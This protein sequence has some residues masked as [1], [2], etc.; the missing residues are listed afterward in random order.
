MRRTIFLVII[1]GFPLFR[2]AAEFQLDFAGAAG[3][4][5]EA[6][7]ELQNEYMAAAIRE[8]AWRWGIRAYMPRLSITASEDDRLSEI[9]ADSFLKNYSVNLDQLIWDGGR[10]P[11]SRRMEKADQDLARS[12]L[13]QMA[14]NIADSAVSAYSYVL[15]GRRILEIREKALE[16]LDE[17]RRIMQREAGLGLIRPLDLAD[18]EITI[19]LE[20]LEIQS[21]SMDLEEAEWRFREML[22][23]AELPLLSERIDT[24]K[25]LALPGKQAV[26]ALA[27]S[28]N[29]ELAAF[30]YSIARRQAE[31]KAVSLSWCPT[32]RMTGSFALSG[33]RYPLSRYSWSVGLSVDFSS[34]WLSGNLSAQTGRD[35]PY[36]KNARLQQTAS[37][38]P[39]PGA[40]FS[41]RSAELALAYERT[42]YETALREIHSAADRSLNECTMLDRKR[43]LAARALELEGEKFRLAELRL[44]LGEIT[45]LDLMEARLDY[46][47][48]EASLVEAAVQVQRAERALERFLDFEPGELS[49]LA[50]IA[51][52]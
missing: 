35:P 51:G 19:A 26:R 10:L 22:G 3:M 6:S 42:R 20:E 48:R 8:G 11:L 31:L 33:R 5:V 47:R 1:L 14:G 9:G 44:S 12:G 49:A 37:P 24:Q 13:K 18:A 21:L 4:A 41:V 45:R 16:S 52:I 28:R 17:Q 36:D 27:E 43:A 46:S 39:D 50:G 29:P 7:K 38:A 25:M 40:V 32:L 2:A 15:Q 23:L 30:R 34:A